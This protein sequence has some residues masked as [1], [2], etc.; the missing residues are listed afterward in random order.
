MVLVFQTEEITTSLWPRSPD[1]DDFLLNDLK[2][3]FPIILQHLFTPLIDFNTAIKDQPQTSF[4]MTLVVLY[5]ADLLV[6][7]KAIL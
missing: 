1:F 5:T 6:V 2:E 4:L 7:K 3:I